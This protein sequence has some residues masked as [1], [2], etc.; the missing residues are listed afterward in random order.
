M[1]TEQQINEA[2][3]KL[4]QRLQT[5][6]LNETQT[7]L[8]GGMLNALVWAADGADSV[9]MDRMLSDEPLAIGKD[10][11]SG[12]DVLRKLSEE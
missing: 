11:R 5:P 2:R 9:T 3:T 4:C 12:M 6:G 8:I 10:P 1:K 7:V